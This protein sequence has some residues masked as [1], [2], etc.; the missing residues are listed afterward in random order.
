MTQ[1]YFFTSDTHFSHRNVIKY[2]DRPFADA[3]EMNESIIRNWN[4]VVGAHDMV[5]HLG[6]VSFEKDRKN[7]THT[8]R[9]LNGIKHIVWGNHDHGM[10][11]AILAADW[12]ELGNLHEISVPPE[13]NNG[14][15]QRIVHCHYA[16]RVWNQSHRGVWQLFGHSHNTMKDDP[17]LL[18]CDVGVDCWN[19][20]P[21]SMSQ[22]NAVMAKKKW[23]G[24]DHHGV[25]E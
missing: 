22:L 16:M 15:G 1:K 18:S 14:R 4:N 24:I 13:A 7:L 10:K 25:R 17:N 20:T 9:R 5:F 12:H 6:D 3:D 21:V 8:L 11:T 19:Y 2:C 23:V